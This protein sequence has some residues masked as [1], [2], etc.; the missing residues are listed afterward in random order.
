M[1]IHPV[2]MTIA[3]SDSSSGA[4]VQAD[5]RA[6]RWFNVYGSSA[7]TCITA[8]NPEEVRSVFALP[9][10]EVR[11]QIETVMDSLQ[12]KAVKT[13]MLYSSDIINEVVDVLEEYKAKGVEPKLVID[14]VM[15]STSGVALINDEAIQTMKER[16]FPIA[17]IVT[18]NIP[19]AEVLSGMKISSLDDMHAAAK[20]LA[21]EF[22]TMFLIKGGHGFDAEATD[23]LFSYNAVIQ[24]KGKRIENPLSTHGTGCSLGSAIAACLAL[25]Y[26]MDAAVKLAKDYVTIGIEKACRIGEKSYGMW[27]RK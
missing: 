10:T 9:V 18:P 4:G 14:P 3:G 15:I 24:L 6:F 23:V 22:D 17:K 12:V 27:P 21:I 2:A 16:L 8:Q 25:E 13:G 11:Q 26:D 7:I 20:K 5:L 1:K 19:E